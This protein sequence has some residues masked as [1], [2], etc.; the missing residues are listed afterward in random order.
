MICVAISRVY[1]AAHF[2]HQVILG[3]IFG[4]LIGSFV[5]NKLPD[6]IIIKNGIKNGLTKQTSKTKTWI[7]LSIILLIVPLIIY[8][9]CVKILK[10]DL[11]WTLEKATNGCNNPDWVH[12]ATNP[13][14]TLFK[15]FGAS[16][17]MS[18][19]S[20]NV[21]KISQKIIYKLFKFIV[22]VTII[23]QSGYW[24]RNHGDSF[25]SGQFYVIG[26]L[27]YGFVPLSL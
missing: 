3:S 15:M 6:E 8:N 27:H 11:D 22:L 5:L 26:F 19:Y 9:L 21:H 2:P 12:K 13:M 16:I 10:I 4:Y 18:F 7:K 24:F 20:N 17:G 23:Y 25:S 14:T 1:L